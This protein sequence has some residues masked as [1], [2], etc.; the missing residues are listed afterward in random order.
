[1]GSIK[2]AERLMAAQGE[3]QADLKQGEARNRKIIRTSIVGILANVLLAGF[4]AVVGILTHSIAIVLD[5][6]N[7]LSDAASSLITIVGTKLA[8]READK[9]HP[10]G[11][12]RIEYLTAMV[13][14]VIVLYAG[15]TSFTESVKK[16]I[17]PDTPD[18]SI[19]SLIIVAVGVAV[20]IVLGRYVKGVGEKVNSDSLVNSG[21]DARLD[22]IISASTLAA[23]VIFLLTDLSL[24]AWLGAVISLVIIKSGIE[25]L[26]D[27]LSQILGE[28][29][30][31]D[32][33]REIKH[34]VLSFPEVSGAYDLV[35]N[36]YGPDTFNGSVH[37]EVPDTMSAAQL[38]E[39]IRTITMTV[40]VK[41]HV[42]LTAIGVYSV[43]THDDD[44]AHMRDRIREAVLAR[45]HVLQMHGF[46]VNEEKKTIRFDVVVSFDAPDRHAE[47][48]EICRLVQELY[49]DYTLQIALDT[50]FTE[51]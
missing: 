24:E 36:N 21:E 6:V 48:A 11:Y 13:I 27:T 39:L 7:N 18:Y 26:R 33:A 51:S 8:A 50:D 2:E 25:M 31:A 41:H 17:S 47:H 29:A 20:K 43:N 40:Y 23:A 9:K 28:R 16:I 22:A 44:A 14:S 15:I 37:I 35:L 45:E 5:A 1:M 46:Y 34:T 30:D 4:K 12:G 38:D 49:P 3:G 32:L 19:V 10:F 42:I